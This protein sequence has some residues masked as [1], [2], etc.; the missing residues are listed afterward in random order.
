MEE[1]PTYYSHSLD[2]VK[3][4]VGDKTL[5]MLEVVGAVFPEAKYQRHT[6]RFYGSV[7]S[8]IPCS[9]VYLVAK[10]LQTIHT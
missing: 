10:I 4:I 1:T 8:V 7:F 6:A 5:G 3:L 2:G 9:N